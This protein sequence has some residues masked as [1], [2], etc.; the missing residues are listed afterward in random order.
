MIFDGFE[1]TAE[2]QQEL[3]DLKGVKLLQRFIHGLL[4]NERGRLCDVLDEV[5]QEAGLYQQGDDGRTPDRDTA[6]S[7]QQANDLQASPGLT[8]HGRR[9]TAGGVSLQERINRGEVSLLDDVDCLAEEEIPAHFEEQPDQD[10]GDEQA[11]TG[12]RECSQVLRT[13]ATPTLTAQ[14]T[15]MIMRY[16][17]NVICDFTVQYVQPIWDRSAALLALSDGGYTA[18]DDMMIKLENFAQQ[19]DA[20][21]SVLAEAHKRIRENRRDHSQ[22]MADLMLKT[23]E[24][25]E[26]IMLK[27]QL[28]DEGGCPPQVM[29]DTE[30]LIK[31]ATTAVHACTYCI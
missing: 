19:H 29:M 7:M 6:S 21:T 20:V 4:S 22:I 15:N 31:Q 26:A 14:D 16:I 5:A 17:T 8:V 27:K 2:L 11:R 12:P 9:T 18:R 1:T 28:E 3:Q 25:R 23:S 13:S 10:A 24:R 30:D